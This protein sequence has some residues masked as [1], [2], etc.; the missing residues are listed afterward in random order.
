[1]AF[2]SFDFIF[3]FLPAFLFLYYLVPAKNRSMVLFAGSALFYVYGAISAPWSVVL[4]G[5]LTVLTYFTGLAVGGE[6]KDAVLPTLILTISF[7]VLLFFKYSGFFLGGESLSLPLGISFYIFSMSAYILDVYRGKTKAEKSFVRYAACVLMFPKLLSGP[8]APYGALL[9]EMETLET[10]ESRLR[11][12]NVDGG[13][14]TF[15]YGLGMKVLLADRLSGLWNEATG[16]GYE[17][18]SAPMAWLCALAFSLRLYFDFWGYSLMAQGIGEMLGYRLPDNFNHPY[19]ARTMTDFWRRWHVTLGAWFREYLYIPL[20]GSRC[21]KGRMALNLLIVWL[22]TGVW[23]G[24]TGNY[25]LWA[26]YIFLIIVAE[27]FLYGKYL[28]QTKILSHVIMIPLTLIGWLLFAITDVEQIWVYLA[29]L[30]AFG[31]T[32][33]NPRDYLTA[34][35]EYGSYLAAG[36]VLSIPAVHQLWERKIRDSAL[37]TLILLAI[38]AVSLYF[39]AMGQNDPFMYSGF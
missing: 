6:D 10:V 15:L 32:A 33:L 26:G 5:A 16:I 29:R 27:K 39:L 38:F 3:V 4:L 14:R 22:A 21:S 24:A 25:L 37:G 20:G 17:S 1:M 31:A 35:S 11:F 36:V 12:R 13:L 34:L 30:F 23:H 7:G 19:A 18:L 28:S 8:I 2:S 9:S